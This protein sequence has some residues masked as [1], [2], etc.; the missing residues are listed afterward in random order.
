[1]F[2]DDYGDYARFISFIQAR[3]FAEDEYIMLYPD[4]GLTPIVKAGDNPQTVG[5]VVSYKLYG[6]SIDIKYL[7][8]ECQEF[9]FVVEEYEQSPESSKLPL[10]ESLVDE[11]KRL[12][13]SESS[14]RPDQIKRGAR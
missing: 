12:L 11:W 7:I 13:V 14:P 2:S 1:M 5:T 3:G 4:R 10:P 6:K 9:G 8:V